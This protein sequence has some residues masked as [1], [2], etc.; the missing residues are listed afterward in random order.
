[1][2]SPDR[3]QS[4]LLADPGNAE[5]ACELADALFAQ[6][7]FDEA[8]RALLSL[9][10]ER[11]LILAVRFRLARYGLMQGDYAGAEAG[12]AQLTAQGHP[13]PALWHDLAF[14]QLCQGHLAPARATLAEAE[15][16]FGADSART[17]LAARIALFERNYPAAEHELL[18]ALE[19]EPVHPVAM[20]L[21]ALAS[22]DSGDP[23]TAGTL[24]DNCLAQYPDQHEALL[25]A[26]TVALWRRELVQADTAFE[27]ALGWHPGSGRA[28]SG[29]GQ[30]LLL[31]EQLEG[32]RA[33]L[34]RAVS[35]MP[36]HIGTWHALAWAQLLCGDQQAAELSYQRAYDLDRNFAESHGGLALVAALDGRT[37]E[38]DAAIRRAL[39]LDPA[40]LTA[41]YARS[42]RLQDMGETAQADELL[43]DLFSP[44]PMPAGIGDVR[45]FATRLRARLGNR[46]AG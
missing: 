25:V 37:E 12:F 27:R 38:A 28:L 16:R 23:D 11:Q 4:F 30:L 7:R 1:M 2:T 18:R 24:A 10:E 8:R 43:A 19:L 21:R 22:L 17:V 3:L 36:D 14:A 5:L 35:A 45:E 29:M 33:L 41:R 6:G 34:E 15:S 31:R 20:G 32:G 26:G 39:R 9:P 40:C 46:A 44:G 42:L 13:V